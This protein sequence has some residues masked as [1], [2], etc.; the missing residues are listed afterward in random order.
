MVKKV[1]VKYAVFTEEKKKLCSSPS[2]HK[3]ILKIKTELI[4]LG[5]GN[6]VTS[7]H[8]FLILSTVKLSKCDSDLI[9]KYI[10]A[11]RDLTELSYCLKYEVNP[12]DFKCPICGEL[13]SFKSHRSS[14]YNYECKNDHK[15]Y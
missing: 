9:I 15:V 6:T 1:K 12:L 8:N 5:A 2:Y 11:F 3:D 10:K 14:L 4:K 13:M 7:I